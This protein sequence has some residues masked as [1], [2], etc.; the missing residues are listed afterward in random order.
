MTTSDLDGTPPWD[1]P[2]DASDW[3]LLRKDGAID[4][5][6]ETAFEAWLAADP[7]RAADY[8]EVAATHHAARSALDWQTTQ[9]AAEA[10]AASQRM[11]LQRRSLGGLAVAAAIALVTFA[12]LYAPGFLGSSFRTSVGERKVVT[13]EDGSTVHLNGATEI[14]VR[15]RDS[16]R[17]IEL[18]SGEAL[19][20]V[21]K[22]PA[23]P[24]RV[25]AAGQVVEAVGTAFDVDLQAASVDVAVREGRVA[26]GDAAVPVAARLQLAEGQAVTTAGST[27]GPVRA[28]AV[29]Q[30][31]AWRRDVLAFQDTKL[32]TIVVALGRHYAGD[33]R[34]TDP[35]LK[36]RRFTG[37]I[38]LRD[39]TQTMQALERALG[40]TIRAR[41]GDR[42]EFV[43]AR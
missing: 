4:P 37:T 34:I 2:Q 31:G 22:N 23:R 25:H 14:V 40:V 18:K 36:E 1:N 10:H 38:T 28:V 16:E 39:R 43:A 35:K 19:F 9:R 12:G 29:E 27:I 20:E 21:A 41:D 24:F 7:A 17:A 13:L 5:R 6:R 32:A 11:R 33:F 15:F 26:F 30:I 42:F 3:F 8:A